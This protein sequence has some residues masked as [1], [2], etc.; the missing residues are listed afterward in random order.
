MARRLSSSSGVAVFAREL[1]LGAASAGSAV[2][3]VGVARNAA[4]RVGY[5]S[6][7]FRVGTGASSALRV[8]AS[9]SGAS[10]GTAQHGDALSISASAEASLCGGAKALSLS[11][12][13]SWSLRLVGLAPLNSSWS[14]PAVSVADL[15]AALQRAW[16][17]R[18]SPARWS[19]ASGTL[20]AGHSA[21]FEVSATAAVASGGAALQ[22]LSGSARAQVS[23][24]ATAGLSALLSSSSGSEI[25]GSEGSVVAATVRDLDGLGGAASAVLEWECVLVPGAD[26]A[27][28]GSMAAAVGGATGSALASVARSQSGAISC[29]SDGARSAAAALAAAQDLAAGRVPAPAVDWSRSPLALGGLVAVR[30]GALRAGALMLSVRAV[31]GQSGALPPLHRREAVGSVVLQVRSGPALSVQLSAAGSSRGSDGSP[32]VVHPAHLPLPVR[33]QVGGSSAGAGRTVLLS[34]SLRDASSASLV[35]A[36]TDDCALAAGQTLWSLLPSGLRIAAGGASV[37]TQAWSPAA[38]SAFL[39]SLRNVSA[40]MAGGAD[41]SAAATVQSWSLSPAGGSSSASAVDSL[42]S[43]AAGSSSGSSRS[44]TAC[45]LRSSALYEVEVR[46]V[47]PSDGA[48]GS[49]VLRIRTPA[50]A[51]GGLLA[52][53]ATS[54]D[55]GPATGPWSSSLAVAVPA[56]AADSVAFEAR[57]LAGAVSV[58]FVV[59]KPT[60]AAA[61]AL[62]ASP[63]SA[64]ARLDAVMGA[65]RTVLS[66]GV[67][68]QSPMVALPVGAG[69]WGVLVIGAVAQS[70][71]GGVSVSLSA[72][73]GGALLLQAM[74]PVA[75]PEAPDLSDEALV[76]SQSGNAS[77]DDASASVAAAAALIWNSSSAGGGIA[78]SAA[79]ALALGDTDGALSR[80]AG[81]A[82]LLGAVSAS[83]SQSA[84]KCARELILLGEDG[85]TGPHASC[86][87]RGRCSLSGQAPECEAVLARAIGAAAIADAADRGHAVSAG[88]QE[89]RDA[90]CLAPCV[91]VAGWGG[92][93]CGVDEAASAAQR[94]AQVGL[95]STVH[96]M[97]SRADSGT[98]DDQLASAASSVREALSGDVGAVDDAAAS[99][100]MDTLEALSAA[101]VAGSGGQNETTGVMPSELTT[102][103]CR[104]ISDL[105]A[106]GAARSASEGASAALTGT[107]GRRLAGAASAGDLQSAASRA[108][109]AARM[110]FRAKRLLAPAAL[111]GYVSA[112]GAYADDVVAVGGTAVSG[113]SAGL[114]ESAGSGVAALAAS[115]GGTLVTTTWSRGR[116]PFAAAAAAARLQAMA[117]AAASAAAAA[118]TS[119]L[120]AAN[121]SLV[122]GSGTGELTTAVAVSAASAVGSVTEVTM[123]IPAGGAAQAAFESGSG[124]SM[125]DLDSACLARGGANGSLA[126]T[127]GVPATEA[128]GAGDP[129][130]ASPAMGVA[131][132]HVRCLREPLLL[133]LPL[134]AGVTAA[135]FVPRWWSEETGS[136]ATGGVVV[137]SVDEASRT[138]V[139]AT[140]HLTGFAAT[141][142][143]VLAQARLPSLSRDV[144]RL[145]NYLR[146][147]NATPALVL[148]GIVLLFAVAWLVAW[149]Y[150]QADRSRARFMAA[151]RALV[152]AYGFTDVPVQERAKSFL[153][154]R[155]IRRSEELMLRR[156]LRRQREQML[157]EGRVAP[158]GMVAAHFEQP[159]RG[160]RRIMPSSSHESGSEALMHRSLEAASKG[161]AGRSPAAA[162]ERPGMAG[163][164]AMAQY[165]RWVCQ[166]FMMKLRSDH[167]LSFC[168]APP[169]A[170]V[171]F[172]RT[173]RVLVL[174]VLWVLS[175][176]VAAVFFGSR[177][178]SIEIR[179]GV[180]LLSALC[181][182]PATFLLPFV[183]KRVA[184]MRSTTWQ[185]GTRVPAMQEWFSVVSSTARR[186]AGGSSEPL[187]RAAKAAASSGAGPAAA[188]AASP[189]ADACVAAAARAGARQQGGSVALQL[190]AAPQSAARLGD[191]GSDLA[192]ATDAASTVG[193][194]EAAESFYL[195]GSS[196]APRKRSWRDP[197]GAAVP[198]HPDDERALHGGGGGGAGPDAMVAAALDDVRDASGVDSDG[199]G[200]VS[201]SE[202]SVE[203]RPIVQSAATGASIGAAFDVSDQLRAASPVVAR[204]PRAPA[205]SPDRVVARARKTNDVVL[206]TKLHAE[207]IVKFSPFLHG[208]PGSATTAVRIASYF[209]LW[210]GLALVGAAAVFAVSA[211]GYPGQD[212]VKSIAAEALR[213]ARQASAVKVQAAW[214]GHVGRRSAL[215]LF[216]LRMW[217]EDLALERTCITAMVYAV[218]L[219]LLAASTF[220]CLVFGVLFTPEQARVWLLTSLA[221]FAL[222]LLVQKPVVIFVNAVALTVWGACTGR[223]ASWTNVSPNFVGTSAASGDFSI[224]SDA[225]SA[226]LMRAFSPRG[227]LVK[228]PGALLMELCSG[229]ASLV[230]AVDD[231]VDPRNGGRSRLG[232]VTSGAPGVAAGEPE[233]DRQPLEQ[234]ESKVTANGSASLVAMAAV[235]FSSLREAT[236]KTVATRSHNG[237]AADNPAPE[238]GAK[239]A[240]AFL[241]AG[242]AFAPDGTA[243]SSDAVAR[244]MLAVRRFLA[245]APVADADDGDGGATALQGAVE[246][247]AS[248]SK[249]L[250]ECAHLAMQAAAGVA[251]AVSERVSSR[252]AMAA[253]RRST[254]AHGHA[255]SP[256]GF[257]P[258]L[259]GPASAASSSAAATAAAAAAAA[260]PAAGGVA[261]EGAAASHSAHAMS[262]AE[263]AARLTA[264]GQRDA[265]R[266]LAG[267]LG[268][269]QGLSAAISR[270][271]ERL[272][273]A[274]APA[275]GSSGAAAAAA[276]R[277]SAATAT[278]DADA[279]D[280]D[281]KS[282]SSFLVQAKADADRIAMEA[283]PFASVLHHHSGCLPKG[284]GNR[285]AAS[286]AAAVGLLSLVGKACTQLTAGK[287]VSKAL[288]SLV[289]SI[290]DHI[291]ALPHSKVDEALQAAAQIF[292]VAGFRGLL[293]VGGSLESKFAGVPQA[294]LDEVIRVTAAGLALG[295]DHM[296]ETTE[297]NASQISS[298]DFRATAIKA[299]GALIMRDDVIGRCGTSNADFAISNLLYCTHSML[300][301]VNSPAQALPPKVRDG[302]LSL[303]TISVEILFRAL[304]SSPSS[305]AKDV[306]S[307]SEQLEFTIFT[308][309]SLP[310]AALLNV[311]AL[312]LLHTTVFASFQ[313]WTVSPR[314]PAVRRG[315]LLRSARILH[316]LGVLQRSPEILSTSRTLAEQHPEGIPPALS[317]RVLLER[318]TLVTR[319]IAAAFGQYGPPLDE[320]VIGARSGELCATSDAHDYSLPKPDE[321]DTH[322][323]VPARRGVRS[324]IDAGM[325]PLLNRPQPSAY[326]SQGFCRGRVV[327]IVVAHG[328]PHFAVMPDCTNVVVATNSPIENLAVASLERERQR[329]HRSEVEAAAAGRGTPPA[330]LSA[331]Q[332]KFSVLRPAAS[333]DPSFSPFRPM[334]VCLVSFAEATM[335]GLTD[336]WS[337]DV[338]D[339]ADQGNSVPRLVLWRPIAPEGF[340]AVGMAV[341]VAGSAE[342]PAKESCWCV[343]ASLTQAAGEAFSPLP[344]LRVVP[345]PPGSLT[346]E[347]LAA[348]GAPRAVASAAAASEGAMPLSEAL[349][350][351]GDQASIG[352]LCC[353]SAAAVVAPGRPAVV[354]LRADAPGD[355]AKAGPPEGAAARMGATN[356]CLVSCLSGALHEEAGV[357]QEIRR[358]SLLAAASILTVG[359]PPLS[360]PQ[361]AML[362]GGSKL[363]VACDSIGTSVLACFMRPHTRPDG[364]LT[365]GVSILESHPHATVLHQRLAAE[366]G[367]VMWHD[368]SSLPS[369]KDADRLAS[370]CISLATKHSASDNRTVVCAV[371]TLGQL[372]RDVSTLDH[373]LR[374]A[375]KML[376]WELLSRRGSLE[377]ELRVAPEALVNGL[378]EAAKED[379]PRAMQEPPAGQCCATM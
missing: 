313:E 16:S 362:F 192:A 116:S 33:A 44:V 225:A 173:Q 81:A 254:P 174:C 68:A 101:S 277:S 371:L 191:A 236:L 179:A 32:S 237:D 292:S 340:A 20:P 331:F 325:R 63:S 279:A 176:A 259:P 276:A 58:S 226:L 209:T 7:A 370:V 47:R 170:L 206:L 153:R 18:A 258:S 134:P 207:I 97:A 167:P 127:Y 241:G 94:A 339:I 130:A 260:S 136:W 210:C 211:E 375:S 162:S 125:L 99:L 223:T 72:A 216:E 205:A 317:Q 164:S 138:A 168:T 161:A 200:S 145:R 57:G 156:K 103:V 87:G 335:R 34:W 346:R 4:G 235:I 67:S 252:S 59:F 379:M 75:V 197:A 353:P 124:G 294:Q 284:G 6:V 222:D 111:L 326:L 240:D 318:S 204:A 329:A 248:V 374:T 175:M 295:A 341:S 323:D 215:R 251:R 268:E 38:P 351:G 78:A 354:R 256:S 123:L 135:D 227:E 105:V 309:L 104:A 141:A 344:R 214:R 213:Q 365:S 348:A 181:M 29:S 121:A 142:E 278:A 46:A 40:A 112:G 1:L 22:T 242:A 249:S 133:R 314:E 89:L 144:G 196:L 39:A 146:P 41:A 245:N 5:G 131:S 224:A 160:G 151:R 27:R 178:Q 76:A 315:V 107:T 19:V 244:G 165:S 376:L 293:P 273:G 201:S 109:E 372:A 229:A 307:N 137:L 86:S 218:A 261:G 93:A 157:A 263:Q 358:A 122:G 190:R 24:T 117:D 10:A 88:E 324:G 172:T 129:A 14:L 338:K 61:E 243:H 23:V 31:A 264:D 113:T 184:S 82:S 267:L 186:R 195:A 92:S 119:A 60:V 366:V 128:A 352:K 169:E 321:H 233:D 356:Q 269:T 187:G 2:E 305:V 217:E 147:E 50:R 347:A 42:V 378:A 355:I 234:A 282:A 188:R 64:Q 349:A 364:L 80:V 17:K 83:Q 69:E 228:L 302:I 12:S 297:P 52:V 208:P 343:H 55:A 283:I 238:L 106:S 320:M 298:K 51:S 37:A 3:V 198:L 336:G 66:S 231:F 360:P 272:A 45:A 8:R 36:F 143:A 74:S 220:V 28:L 250:C 367:F 232:A 253:S 65:Q 363:K 180:V 114:A 25:G 166:L 43:P 35:P 158:D 98:S 230:A 361:V 96:S 303:A 262:L 289:T 369:G 84:S 62:A 15:D 311:A 319:L 345:C 281:T 299:W 30:A 13:P 182:L 73:S 350:L 49:A 304:L 95:L 274:P 9:V 301:L 53:S 334:G 100:A 183:F 108:W 152:L 118:G 312:L 333:D 357:P 90:G 79:D 163:S 26:A 199:G 203:F 308:C 148:G 219:L 150:D 11:G 291:A 77:T 132:P 316:R 285:A 115:G 177:P 255:A 239:Q 185:A 327:G 194:S 328:E 193:P 21:E 202:G 265:Q 322:F 110:A 171:V 140:T 139:V 70:A 286:A 300:K 377:T 330:P 212:S 342:G 102:H 290:P 149:R 266:A 154:L 159:A 246:S 71:D 310:D 287:S 54:T 126:A 91:C 288:A 85:A 306:I 271:Q 221:S 373:S 280:P 368:P 296:A 332:P 120:P 257:G 155:D 48:E 189:G 270:E 337:R 275:G 359:L 247:C 56:L